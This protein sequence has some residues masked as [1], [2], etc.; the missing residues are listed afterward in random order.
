MTYK[1]TNSTIV[2]RTS[3]G[4]SIPADPANRD[5]AE[6][7]EWLA[8]GNTPD[9][10]DPPPDTS[11]ADAQAALDASDRTLSRCFEVGAV[12][13]QEW[14]DYRAA[15]RLVVRNGGTLPVRPAYPAGT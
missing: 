9:P 3:D 11:R 2:I 8:A 6:Y 5:Y 15:L 7:L 13:P 12:V 14:R 10:A 1:L 4:A